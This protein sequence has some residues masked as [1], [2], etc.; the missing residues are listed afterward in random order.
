M[1]RIVCR[2]KSIKGHK[3]HDHI[4]KAGLALGTE[5]YCFECG[6]LLEEPGDW[7][8]HKCSEC[9]NPLVWIAVI[10]YRYCPNCG[11]KFD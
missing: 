11:V 6:E 8:I 2:E 7:V 9:G 10:K 3:K 4:D 5:K 1:A